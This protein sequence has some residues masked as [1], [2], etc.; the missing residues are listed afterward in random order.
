[1][2]RIPGRVASG[3]IFPVDEKNDKTT[4]NSNYVWRKIQSGDK[5][6]LTKYIT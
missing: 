5:I 4:G 2:Y 1:M 6:N 3:D